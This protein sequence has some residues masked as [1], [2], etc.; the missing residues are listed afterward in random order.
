MFA[1]G[2]DPSEE[3]IEENR[4]NYFQK[5]TS[6]R[7]NTQT[8]ET[9]S[10]ITLALNVHL[11]RGQSLVMNTSEVFMSLETISIASLSNKQVK[12]IENTQIR[13]PFNAISNI[14]NDTIVSLRV[15]SFLNPLY[16]SNLL[17]LSF[18][19]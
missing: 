17:I 7:I 3:N 5:E 13:F 2:N 19:L 6:K 8:E 14:S 4:N 1:D 9:I 16:S 18:S 11:N 12:Q 10:W 15:R